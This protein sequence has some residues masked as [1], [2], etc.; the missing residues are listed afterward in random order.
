MSDIQTLLLSRPGAAARHHSWWRLHLGACR[1]VGGCDAAAPAP[2]PAPSELHARRELQVGCEP[3]GLAF[4]GVPVSRILCKSQHFDAGAKRVSQC[5]Q[6]LTPRSGSELCKPEAEPMRRVVTALTSSLFMTTMFY[7]SSVFLWQTVDFAAWLRQHAE[8][9]DYVV[10]SLALGEGRDFQLLAAML[11]D[12]VLPLVDKVYVRWRY[13]LAVSA[14]ICSIVVCCI[15]ITV[16]DMEAAVHFGP[17][18]AAGCLFRAHHNELSASILS[19]WQSDDA[20]VC[21]ADM[22]P[23]CHVGI[24]VLAAQ[25]PLRVP[26]VKGRACCGVE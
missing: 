6:S 24:R 10:L 12:G 3:A 22:A 23:N 25:H 18:Q 9:K 11:A 14:K 17:T 15:E 26:R 1:R 2:S 19:C 5:S 20:L 7:K 21:C 8:D 16:Y 13:Q 4:G